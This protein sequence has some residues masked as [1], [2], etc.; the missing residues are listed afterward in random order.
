MN[1]PNCNN[2]LKSSDHYCGNCGQKQSLS[3]EFEIKSVLAQFFG[4]I[5]SFD[6]KLFKTLKVLF[7]P[8]K[9]YQLFLKGKRASYMH[10][11]RL[12]IFLNIFLFGLMLSYDDTNIKDVQFRKAIDSEFVWGNDTIPPGEVNQFTPEELLVRYPQE[13]FM[14]SIAFKQVVHMYQ[15]EE[16][17]LKDVTEKLP[18]LFFI[19]IPLISFCSFII[20]RKHKARYLHHF[21][22]WTNIISAFILVN[23]LEMFLY[24]FTDK[25]HGFLAALVVFCPIFSFWSLQRVF[26][27]KG[28]FRKLFKCWFY[29]LLGSLSFLFSMIVVLILGF[30]M[31]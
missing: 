16:S 10:P 1:C 6:S 9:Y 26:P 11:L 29:L 5:L 25:P 18:W 24:N 31:F 23:S 14:G 7:A 2:G 8:A 22:L 21:L 28:F 20:E 19:L 15:D 17:F 13:T 12:F 27:T 30:F 3:E 4:N